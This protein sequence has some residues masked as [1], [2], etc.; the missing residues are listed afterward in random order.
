MG[1]ALIKKGNDGKERR[2]GTIYRNAKGEE[3]IALNGFG[4]EQKAW[5]E[6]KTG[7]SSNK[8]RKGEG[9]SNT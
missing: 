8:R 9:F 6:I 4:K 7:K 2:Y 3:K 1:R 5:A